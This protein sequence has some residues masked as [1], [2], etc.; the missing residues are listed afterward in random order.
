MCVYIYIYMRLM[1]L[2][3]TFL[4]SVTKLEGTGAFILNSLTHAV[5][6]APV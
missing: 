6:R 4:P 1:S 2:K 5:L 3:T